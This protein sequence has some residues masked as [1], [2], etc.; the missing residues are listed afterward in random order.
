MVFLLSIVLACS[1]IL[2]ILLQL[3]SYPGKPRPFLD[4]NGDPLP[5]SISEKVFVNINGQEQ[6]MF[7]KS[8]DSTNPILLHLHGGMPEYFLTQNYPIRLEDHFTVVW[9]EQRGAGLSY[10]SALSPATMSAEQ[11][12]SDV[13]EVT[14]YLRRRF[15]KE[16]IYLMAHSGGTFIG[17]QAVARRPQLYFAYIGVAQ[18]SRQLKSEALAY[19]YMLRQFKANGNTSM[20]RRLEA[21]P[22]SLTGGV[23]EAYLSVRDD[24]MHSLGVGTTHDMRSVLSGIFLP[25]LRFQEY[26]LVEKVN[27][28]RGKLRSG[29]GSLWNEIIATDLT[30]TVTELGLPV[31]FF[32]GI[33][34]YTVSYH[35]AKSYFHE[36]RAPKKGFYTFDQSAH[37]PIFEEP[38]RTLTILLKD[39]LAGTTELADPTVEVDPRKSR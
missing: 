35:E 2:L 24:A 12:I 4:E 6:G 10:S 21:A 36:V 31:Y 11:F 16:K 15:G 30:K 37:S 33:H 18:I 27:L 1:L 26:T 32:H 23:P 38:E 29:V 22:V 25:S 13:F 28:W 9:W 19:D 14:D 34:D 3:W 20:A 7:I 5:G 8:K 39:V 17:I